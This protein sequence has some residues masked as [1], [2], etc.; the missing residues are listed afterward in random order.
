MPGHW[1]WPSLGMPEQDL[2]LCP[3]W[4]GTFFS[5]SSAIVGVSD[6]KG[7]NGFGGS[8]RH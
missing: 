2:A 3:A 5:C 8:W 1:R 6:A 7:Q 4:Q